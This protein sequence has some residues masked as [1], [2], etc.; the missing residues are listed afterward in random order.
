[1][2]KIFFLSILIICSKSTLANSVDLADSVFFAGN[3]KQAIQL[4]TKCL[5][6]NTELL[7]KQIGIVLLRRGI[8][9]SELQQ[10]ENAF[11]DYFEAL[12]LFEKNKN[13]LEEAKVYLNLSSLYFTTTDFA[14]TERYIFK[15]EK[16]FAQLH[17]TVNLIRVYENN[18]LWYLLLDHLHNPNLD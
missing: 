1:M 2:F 14:N 5:V 12:A 7:K 17:D 9:Y 10:N 15:A 4:Y 3:Y 13:E 6:D 8:C 18:S 16:L 11:K